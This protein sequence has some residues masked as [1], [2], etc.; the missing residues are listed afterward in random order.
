M[1]LVSRLVHCRSFTSAPFRGGTPGRR[2]W[3]PPARDRERAPWQRSKGFTVTRT[4]SRVPALLKTR[5]CG[6]VPGVAGLD[7]A[8][9]P[10]PLAPAT[11]HQGPL[12]CPEPRFSTEQRVPS[13]PSHYFRRISAAFL[14]AKTVPFEA[15]MLPRG[16]PFS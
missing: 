5:H 8:G 1:L 3:G 14:A 4:K 12:R 11:D 16:R 13:V 2:A 15:C 7:E 6:D 10:G 9:L